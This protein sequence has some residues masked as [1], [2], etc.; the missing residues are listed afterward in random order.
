MTN[1]DAMQKI[2]NNLKNKYSLF[3]EF[4]TYTNALFKSADNNE[5]ENFGVTLNLRQNIMK[6]IDEIDKDNSRLLAIL[7]Q[8]DKTVI[9]P[10]LNPGRSL[11]GNFDNILHADIFECQKK[12]LI[13][14]RKI[15]DVDD[16]VNKIVNKIK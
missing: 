12:I 10:I 4:E 3:L 6:K 9:A 8:N 7:P 11:N 13:L 16:K 15:I 2:L 5:A 1:I 14:V